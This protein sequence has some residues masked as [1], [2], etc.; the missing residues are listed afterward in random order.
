VELVLGDARHRQR[1]PCFTIEIQQ[2]RYS[3]HATADEI[4]RAA[5]TGRF[6]EHSLYDPEPTDSEVAECRAH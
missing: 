2:L 3:R 1:K 6:I 4:K 5:T